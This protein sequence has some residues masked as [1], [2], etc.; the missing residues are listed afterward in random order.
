[1]ACKLLLRLLFIIH[2]ILDWLTDGESGRS[3]SIKLATL[4]NIE[5]GDRVR[6]CNHQ[7]RAQNYHRE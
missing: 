5:L 1:L 2:A 7:L 6:D 3:S 4:G